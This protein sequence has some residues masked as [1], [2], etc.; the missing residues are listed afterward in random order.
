M[1]IRFSQTIENSKHT[2][3]GPLFPNGKARLISKLVLM[4]EDKK[5][6]TVVHLYLKEVGQLG[7]NYRVFV[8]GL[9]GVFWLSPFYMARILDINYNLSDWRRGYDLNDVYFIN[10]AF[11]LN[12][13]RSQFFLLNREISI[14]ILK[15]K[16]LLEFANKVSKYRKSL[17][18]YGY[19]SELEKN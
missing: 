18:T 12:S 13:N 3:I 10:K 9:V 19:V 14:N 7:I 4:R 15:E 16:N 6:G 5:R 2:I 11:I 17:L 1:A 8:L